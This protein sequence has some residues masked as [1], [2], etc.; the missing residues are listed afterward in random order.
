MN[1]LPQAHNPI[2][3]GLRQHSI[4]EFYPV[5]IVGVG[6]PVQWVAENLLTGERYCDPGSHDRAINAARL[7]KQR[8]DHDNGK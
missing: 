3:G 6:Y 1:I 2:H 8:E 7:A 4:G 5:A